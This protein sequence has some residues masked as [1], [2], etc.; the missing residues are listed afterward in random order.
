MHIGNNVSNMQL[1]K[2]SLFVKAAE[3]NPLSLDI[4]N[5]LTYWHCPFSPRIWLTSGVNH[6][7]HGMILLAAT[8]SFSHTF[9]PLN[10]A[11][12]NSSDNLH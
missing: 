9:F 4:I 8:I 5:H 3:L 1:R 6:L 7:N 10:W 12:T 11:E 2:T